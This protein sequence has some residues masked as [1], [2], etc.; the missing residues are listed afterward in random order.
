MACEGSACIAPTIANP[1]RKLKQMRIRLFCP[2]IIQLFPGFLNP[3][4]YHFCVS[5]AGYILVGGKSSRMGQD[6]AF[7]PFGNTTLV[8]HVAETVR[9]AAGSVTLIGDPANYSDLG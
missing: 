2:L 4:C 1:T 9:A 3:Q 7:L 6:K 8:Q 5:R